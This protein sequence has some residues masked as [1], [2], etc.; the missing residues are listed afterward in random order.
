MAQQ[1]YFLNLLPIPNLN[2]S[3]LYITFWLELI[4][5]AITQS[6]A[7]YRLFLAIFIIFTQ[8]SLVVQLLFTNSFLF[9]IKAMLFQITNS[10]LRLY[11]FILI[12]TLFNLS[13]F[14]QIGLFDSFFPIP[15]ST[16]LQET[17]YF[18]PCSIVHIL[19][20]LFLT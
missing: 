11:L 3:T 19:V 16:F 15:F 10:T 9:C 5:I 17:L 1:I 20:S 18:F 6:I 7:I 2:W 8:H 14:N 4:F 13:S 12:N